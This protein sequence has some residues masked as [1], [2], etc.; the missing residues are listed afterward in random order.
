MGKNSA[1]RQHLAQQVA[2]LMWEQGIQ[3]YRLAKEKAARRLHLDSR[4]L[5]D[6]REI[7]EALRVHSRLFGGAQAAQRE[8]DLLAAAVELM[9][10]LENL[11]PRLVGDLLSDTLTPHSELELHLFTDVPEQAEL[12]L[13]SRGLSCEWHERRLRFGEDDYRNLPALRLEWNGLG[14]KAVVF[15]VRG[16]RQAPLSPID[17]KPMRRAS[18]ADAEIM[19][20]AA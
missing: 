12:L 17:G 11:Q 4:H 10:L 7:A 18:L 2:Q 13:Q 15:P 1:A 16:L 14:V 20:A 8:Q 19:L 3:D 5:P 6:N 9:G